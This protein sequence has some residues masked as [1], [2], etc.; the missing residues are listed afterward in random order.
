MEDTYKCTAGAAEL[1]R[2]PDV[3]VP[4]RTGAMHA[5]LNV[6]YIRA[7]AR[8]M[9]LRVSQA[10]YDS[11]LRTRTE[12]ILLFVGMESPPVIHMSH[13]CLGFSGVGPRSH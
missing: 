2:P 4:A 11:S 1:N 8:R 7:G 12:V 9:W 6:G 3:D 13:L 10:S 5:N